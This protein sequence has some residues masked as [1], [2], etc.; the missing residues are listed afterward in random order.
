[1]HS[2]YH[3][4][5]WPEVE[6]LHLGLW[7]WTWRRRG[8]IGRY[9]CRRKHEC[10]SEREEKRVNFVQYVDEDRDVLMNALD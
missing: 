10:Q 5:S 4:K 2:G 1:M 9:V 7:R 8:P 3:N 6:N